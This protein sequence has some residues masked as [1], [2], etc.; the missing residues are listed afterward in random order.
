MIFQEPMT[1]LNPVHRI[2]RQI[3]E[4]FLLHRKDMDKKAA[5]QAS[6]EILEKVG[7]PSPEI[8][9]GEY[10]H[11]LSGGMRQRAMIAMAL[12]AEAEPGDR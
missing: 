3:S 1:A 9:Y 12:G 6:I 8:R 2:G 11:Q 4:V 7:I 5:W 10:P